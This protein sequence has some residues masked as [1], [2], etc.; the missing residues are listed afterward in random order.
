VRS[1]DDLRR[2]GSELKP[3]GT[4]S[5]VALLPNGSETIVNYRV[6]E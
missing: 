5:V 6:R 4:V 2:V 1:L 3:G